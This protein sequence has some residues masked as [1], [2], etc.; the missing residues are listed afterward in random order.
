MNSIAP[1][2]AA[3]ERP[4]RVPLLAE[5]AAAAQA[6]TL[7]T[8]AIRDWHIPVDPQV[9][10]L[11]T[12]ELVSNAIRHEK[13]DMIR[14][15]VTSSWG[16]LRVYVHDSCR[17][18][19]VPVDAPIDAEAGRGLMLVAGL[20]TNWGHYRTPSG[21]AVYFTLAFETGSGGYAQQRSGG[22]HTYV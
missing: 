11:L 5:P 8:D 6:R 21:K 9:A 1:L 14:L 19:P 4:L 10:G 3:V 16:H 20:S 7:V 17:N 2:R 15:F 22:H 18:P 13:G 12:S